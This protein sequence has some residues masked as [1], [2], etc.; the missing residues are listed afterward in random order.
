MQEISD[1]RGQLF[2]H[3]AA[4]LL[5][6]SKCIRQNIQMAIKFLSTRIKDPD[7]DN[8]KKLTKVMQYLRNTK[9]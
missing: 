2:H 1:E 5:N 7:T 4:K 8:Y 3:L 9:I 6:L